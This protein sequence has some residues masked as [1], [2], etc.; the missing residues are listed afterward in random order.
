[1]GRKS[2]SHDFFVPVLWDGR[3]GH[4]TP[5]YLCCGTEEWVTRLLRTCVVG[6]KSGLHDSFVPVLWDGRV[7]YM[8]PSYLCCGTEE[9]VT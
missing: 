8:T 5:S 6:R 1:M 9:W 2:G 3:V 4:M 7:G